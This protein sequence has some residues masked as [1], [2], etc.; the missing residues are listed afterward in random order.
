MNEESKEKAPWVA[1]NIKR[2]DSDE[3]TTASRSPE[4]RDRGWLFVVS[5]LAVRGLP[6]AIVGRKIYCK[7]TLNNCLQKTSSVKLV[8][9]EDFGGQNATARFEKQVFVD[10]RIPKP[11][12]LSDDDLLILRLKTVASLTR[13]T[14]ENIGVVSIAAK[15][16]SS[17][18][19]PNSSVWFP[20]SPYEGQ[21]QAAGEVC[22]RLFWASNWDGYL[23]P[24][25]KGVDKDIDR[26]DSDDDTSYASFASNK[27]TTSKLPSPTRSLSKFRFQFTKSHHKTQE[28]LIR[29]GAQQSGL[30]VASEN[31]K[32]AGE[33]RTEPIKDDDLLELNTSTVASILQTENREEDAIS[34]P[35]EAARDAKLESTK[36]DIVSEVSFMSSKRIS[37]SSRPAVQVDI[38][39]GR[40][41]IAADRNGWSDPYCIVKLKSYKRKTRIEHRTLTPSWNETVVFGGDENPKETVS[42]DDIITIIV[43]DHDYV[44]F[45]DDLGMI[46][47]PLWAM[48]SHRDENSVASKDIEVLASNEDPPPDIDYTPKLKRFTSISTPVVNSSAKWFA[49]HKTERMKTVRGEIKLRLSFFVG[50]VVAHRFEQSGISQLDRVTMIDLADDASSARSGDISWRDSSG[51]ESSF[52]L[53]RMQQNYVSGQTILRVHVIQARNLIAADSNGKSDPY[54]IV[55]VRETEQRTERINRTLNPVWRA[56]FEFGHVRDYLT[57]TDELEVI[58]KDYDRLVRDDDLGAVRIPL[59]SILGNDCVPVWYA[60]KHI[61]S[62]GNDGANSSLLKHQA[63]Q[64]LGEVELEISFCVVSR[65]GSLVPQKAF[66]STKAPAP[67]MPTLSTRKILQTIAK[68]KQ[69]QYKIYRGKVWF[70][71]VQVSVIG[72]S[73]LPVTDDQGSTTSFVSVSCGR[74]TQYTSV[75]KGTVNPMYKERFIFDESPVPGSLGIGRQDRLFVT[76]R[77]PSSS[78]GQQHQQQHGEAPSSTPETVSRAEKLKGNLLAF[79]TIDM[80]Y[81]IDK[82]GYID[83]DGMQVVGWFK[84]QSTRHS[85]SSLGRLILGDEEVE[86][87][88]RERSPA[89]L[90]LGIMLKPIA[91]TRLM[92]REKLVVRINRAQGLEETSRDQLGRMVFARVLLNSNQK[93]SSLCK[94]RHGLVRMYEELYFDT[95]DPF[96]LD[97]KVHIFI[98]LEETGEA[99]AKFNYTLRDLREEPDTMITGWFPLEILSGEKEGSLLPQRNSSQARKNIAKLSVDNPEI[100]LS[101]RLVTVMEYLKP[102][103]GS[104]DLNLLKLKMDTNDFNYNLRCVVKYDDKQVLT[105]TYAGVVNIAFD[106][107]ECFFRFPVRDM[108]T[109]LVFEV[110]NVPTTTGQAS[111]KHAKLMGFGEISVNDLIEFEAAAVFAHPSML[112]AAEMEPIKLIIKDI[113][114]K[115]IG[116]LRLRAKFTEKVVTGS[117]ATHANPVKHSQKPFS[118]ANL[119]HEMNRTFAL[120]KGFWWL[121]GS[122]NYVLSWENPK[123]SAFGL[124]L[125]VSFCVLDFWK[126]RILIIIP[127]CILI[128]VINRHNDRTYGRF[129]SQLLQ[130]SGV[131]ENDTKARLLTSVIRG[132][133]L[134][135]MDRGGTSDPLVHVTVVHQ[136]QNKIHLQKLGRTR[137]EYKTLNPDWGSSPIGFKAN[138]G[139]SLIQWRSSRDGS[140]VPAFEA[141]VTRE[142]LNKPSLRILLV[143]TRGIAKSALPA[144]TLSDKLHMFQMKAQ[145]VPAS[146]FQAQ[147]NKTT[148]HAK[149]RSGPGSSFTSP[150]SLVR[151]SME[152]PGKFRIRSSSNEAMHDSSQCEAREDGT[153][154]DLHSSEDRGV[155]DISLHSNF[156]M[157]EML[158]RGVSALETPQMDPTISW[159]PGLEW[160]HGD[161]TAVIRHCRAE[162]ELTPLDK[163]ILVDILRHQGN[164]LRAE[165]KF[166]I[167]QAHLNPCWNDTIIIG[168][169]YLMDSEDVLVLS[170]DCSSGAEKSKS[171]LKTLAHAF[172]PLRAVHQAGRDLMFNDWFP[173]EHMVVEAAPSHLNPFQSMKNIERTASSEDFQSKGPVRWEI[174]GE[175]L[176]SLDLEGLQHGSREPKLVLDDTL[177]FS[178][179]ISHEGH[180]HVER[181]HKNDISHATKEKDAGISDDAGGDDIVVSTAK[182]QAHSDEPWSASSAL[183]M[184]DVFD[185][186]DFS[187]RDFIGRATIPLASL[188]ADDSKQEQ[189]MVERWIPLSLRF[190]ETKADRVLWATA[191][192]RS[193]FLSSRGPRPSRTTTFLSRRLRGR[194]Y[195]GSGKSGD[196]Q[197]SPEIGIEGDNL[198]EDDLD[199]HFRWKQERQPFGEILVRMQLFLPEAGAEEAFKQAEQAKKADRSNIVEKS[200]MVFHQLQIFQNFLYG[201][202]NTLEQFKNLWNWS[203][204]RKTAALMFLTC[205][206]FVL[207]LVVPSRFIILFVG[208]FLFTERFRPLGVMIIKL[209]H[210]MALTPTND[211]LIQIYTKGP[212]LGTLGAHMQQNG[213][214]GEEDDGPEVSKISGGRRYFNLGLRLPVTQAKHR[215]AQESRQIIAESDCK[216]FGHLRLLQA[217]RSKMWRRHY[218]AIAHHQVL[219]WAEKEEF[220]VKIPQ[221]GFQELF[222]VSTIENQEDIDFLAKKGVSGPS[223]DCALVISHPERSRMWNHEVHSPEHVEEREESETDMLHTTHKKISEFAEKNF[224]KR[225][226]TYLVANS[227]KK[228]DFWVENLREHCLANQNLQNSKILK[229][230]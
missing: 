181:T 197:D 52:M 30:T 105:Q 118:I 12:Q 17:L 124:F 157:P 34:T 175:V 170:F 71:R 152:I 44:G 163:K 66:H 204:P 134:I 45:D 92:E 86:G 206:L 211:D 199:L 87:K 138:A 223:L 215:E 205:F 191:Q 214:S 75:V 67:E 90:K 228:R 11:S 76:V 167:V 220:L 162:N 180:S 145:T 178:S 19:T 25:P 166:G 210:L 122:L 136:E 24:S 62:K 23:P 149:V 171:S 55:R 80:S 2:S 109:P 159:L 179:R 54:V 7:L 216:A 14:S 144:S 18:G 73:D 132:R 182:D 107:E 154:R 37:Q 46:E 93:E 218:F 225:V 189:P 153:H 13:R 28:M 150:S 148:A 97:D 221:G 202:N 35:S 147:R 176:L 88:R 201:W 101:I 72:A 50:T 186:D 187:R 117:F 1:T 219:F 69:L 188:V 53:G 192:G 217:G 200:K 70:Y 127:F 173:L 61:E 20:L 227:V 125:L 190:D 82:L 56:T 74:S 102:T 64:D 85:R 15:E 174:I 60:L 31:V 8:E 164:S 128:H 99:I 161:P 29:S 47:I 6:K 142:L 65:D 42:V 41:L 33:W 158:F 103:L 177:N 193:T 115:K 184:L 129:T 131:G 120:W 106:E 198:V 38:V 165:H 59:W 194:K 100:N 169:D 57:E 114:Q 40:G 68:S 160:L 168:R 39:E 32:I 5:V 58:V 196:S 98:C 203:H 172:I 26:V 133:N 16:V 116:S 126:E 78:H 113:R 104:I 22:V 84:L 137:T 3:D 9:D 140:R 143:G 89:R 229:M 139:S 141:F 110:W 156:E 79:T 151:R 183:L 213:S 208:I 195:E 108:F 63:V 49:L 43:K 123:V 83:R 4:V 51:V 130:K 36:S 111:S 95:L 48:A 207:F 155:S 21:K 94:M 121:F 112:E 222:E 119:R 212:L 185:E 230:L 135:A 224:R 209:N 27:S 96:E 146:V 91:E 226:R 77:T 10:W 81:I